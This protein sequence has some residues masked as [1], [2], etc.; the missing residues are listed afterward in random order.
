[1][2]CLYHFDLDGH[3]AGAQVK[4]KYPDC[5]MFE[6]NYDRDIPFNAITKDEEIWI[7]DFSL[8]KPED[9]SRLQTITKN[10]TWIDHHISAMEKTK[11]TPIENSKGIRSDKASGAMLT[12]FYLNKDGQNNI[13]PQAIIYVSDYDIGTNKF[14]QSM[15]FEAGSCIYETDPNCEEGLNFWKTLINY[16]LSETLPFLSEITSKGKIIM[17]Y[18]EEV[19]VSIL[20]SIGFEAI[21]NNY[22]CICCNNPGKLSHFIESIQRVV[23]IDSYDLIFLFYKNMEKWVISIFSLDP[24]KVNASELCS[25]FGGGGHKEIGGFALDKLPTFKN[26]QKLSLRI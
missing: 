17:K 26:I 13:P 2:I 7:V 1:M 20:K 12:W 18:R 11:G 21:W 4:L 19:N 10:I 6:M 5:R 22:K 9:W 8:Q 14:E 24:N 25:K 3:C 16:S 23:N 15:Q